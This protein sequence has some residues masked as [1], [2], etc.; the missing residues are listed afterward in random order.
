VRL[1]FPTTPS[2]PWSSFRRVA[3]LASEGP[4]YIMF[5]S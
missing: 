4:S 3:P 1:A 2:K 5:G